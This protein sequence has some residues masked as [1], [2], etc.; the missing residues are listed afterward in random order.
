[1]P[2]LTELNISHNHKKAD[3]QRLRAQL[4]YFVVTGQ[5]IG[6]ATEMILPY[7]VK[8]ILPKLKK[9]L[10]KNEPETGTEEKPAG[11]SEA[12]F[13]EKLYREIDLPE[14][15]I[16]TDY[17]EMVIQVSFFGKQKEIR[18]CD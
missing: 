2:Y 4:V 15:N 17:V 16:Y 12:A 11:G 5:I 13:M 14:Y 9:K 18:K 7:A 10:G 3:F 6:F 8:K 1:M